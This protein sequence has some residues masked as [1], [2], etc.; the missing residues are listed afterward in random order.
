MEA[1][2][3]C[4]I[5]P[6]NFHLKGCSDTHKPYVPNP[7]I[8]NI[9]SHCGHIPFNCCLHPLYYLDFYYHSLLLPTVGSCW[10]WLSVAPVLPLAAAWF[11]LSDSWCN[12]SPPTES[13][14]IWLPPWVGPLAL[15]QPYRL[16]SGVEGTLFSGHHT[17][18]AW[19]HLLVRHKKEVIP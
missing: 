3:R 6:P 5:P 15:T 12:P 16:L 18:S 11:A 19:N 9:W 14:S 17:S 7:H 13:I 1:G 8:E 10:L 2:W 4:P